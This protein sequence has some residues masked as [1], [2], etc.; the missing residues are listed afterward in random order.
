MAINLKTVR[1]AW[2]EL[3]SIV[4]YDKGHESSDY[5]EPDNEDEV[6]NNVFKFCVT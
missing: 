3:N 4:A 1:P 6:D 2:L 5:Y